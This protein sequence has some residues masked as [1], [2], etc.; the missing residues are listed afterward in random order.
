MS[1]LSSSTA[2][3]LPSHCLPLTATAAQAGEL[4]VRVCA[5]KNAKKRVRK[6][7]KKPLQS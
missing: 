5:G 7:C 6:K 2:A 3:C 4:R 1:W